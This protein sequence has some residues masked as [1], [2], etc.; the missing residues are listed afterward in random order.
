M[1][2]TI[3]VGDIHGCYDELL[4]LLGR[5]AFAAD[6]RVVAVG[7]LIV[8]GEKNR[9]V[10]DLFISD[11]RF[12]SVT[13][14]HDLALRRYWH[15][16]PVSLTKAQKSA[17]LE[18]DKER[19]RYS[20]Y[21]DSLPLMIDLGSYVIVHA[22][23]RP[24]VPLE[25]Q[26]T[27]DLT[28]MRTLGPDPKSREGIPWYEEYEGLKTVLFGHWPAREPRRSSHAIGLDTGCVYGHRLTAYIIETGEFISVEA[29]RAYDHP[30]H[31]IP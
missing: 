19:E 14:N 29:Q 4:E 3:V 13:G 24:G 27:E 6:D 7:D 12:S 31:G 26:S 16:E 9:Q 25:A 8:K 30:K 10:L 23:L 1:G 15:D 28:E 22:G 2:R 11:R 17:R 5:A 20:Q 18:L 21:L